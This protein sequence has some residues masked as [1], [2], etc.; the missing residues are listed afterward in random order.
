MSENLVIVESPA[1]AKTI[2]KILGSKYRVMPSYGHVRDLP[3][4]TLGVDIE[5]EFK[6]NYTVSPGKAKVI[7]DLRKAA[8]E[9]EAIYLAPDPDREGEA[10]AWHLLEVLASAA[11]NKP[12]HRISTTRSPAR[13]RAAFR[14]PARSTWCVNAQQGRVIDR[15]VGYTVSPLLWRR[16]KRGLSAGRVQSVALRLVCERSA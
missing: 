7:E 15:I 13:V 6:P 11:K 3:Q 16:I 1:K 5:K 12:F 2:G 4:R 8:R 10:I 9:A 14:T